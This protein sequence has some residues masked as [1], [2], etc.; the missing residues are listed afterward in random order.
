MTTDR[1][2]R[3][4][5]VDY[6]H[7]THTRSDLGDDMHTS[8]VTDR[9]W[10]TATSPVSSTTGAL[11]SVWDSTVEGTQ[12]VTPDY[13]ALTYDSGNGDDDD[14]DYP[15]YDRYG[16]PVEDEEDVES[17]DEDGV[18]PMG[19]PMTI[20]LAG[21]GIMAVGTLAIAAS[22]DDGQVQMSP[23]TF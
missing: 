5:G 23:E 6:S 16:T 9:I 2:D 13:G 18:G 3:S 12:A 15:G 11:G 21:G 17:E 22:G 1:S 8:G 4:F 20:W 10:D 14:D 7:R 19:V